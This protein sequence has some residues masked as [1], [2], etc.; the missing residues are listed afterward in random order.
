VWNPSVIA[1]FAREAPHDDSK[2][3]WGIVDPRY[4]QSILRRRLIE[5]FFVVVTAMLLREVARGFEPLP[6]FPRVVLWAWETPQDLRFIKPGSAAIAFLERTVWLA[7]D[8]VY[9]RPR[10]QPLR[11]NPGTDLIAVARFESA[12]LGLP[13]PASVIHELTP[14]FSIS[15]VH[16][17]QIDFDARQSEQTWYADFLGKLRQ[18]MPA[19]TLL[20]ITALESWCEDSRWIQQ[21]PVADAT[22]MLFRMGPRERV[23]PNRFPAGICRSS[24]GVSTDELPARVPAARRVYFFNPGPWTKDDYEM[25]LAQARRWLR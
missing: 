25:A 12:G 22:A 16:A 7:P 2:K 13:T 18:T 21:L 14:A 5:L 23:P 10:L 6:G 11:F 19:R 24:I 3:G 1:L 9:S 4:N 15:G 8:H 20:T 17:L